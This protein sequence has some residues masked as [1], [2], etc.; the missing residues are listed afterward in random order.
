M[1]FGR[2]FVKNNGYIFKRQSKFSVFTFEIKKRNKE[3]NKKRVRKMP[4][5]NVY[6]ARVTDGLILVN[7]SLHLSMT[8]FLSL[9]PF[10]LCLFVLI[11]F[12]DWFVRLLQW[13]IVAV[14]HQIKWIYLK[15]KSISFLT[16]F[17][18]FFFFFISIKF[19]Y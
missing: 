6:I 8:R 1:N 10:F 16:F 7:K 17:I 12:V 14:H 18:S 3:R 5:E 9:L 4:I 13:S 15:I 2:S 19:F 11:S